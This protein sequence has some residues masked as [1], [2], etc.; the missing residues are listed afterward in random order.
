MAW[1]FILFHA[2]KWWFIHRETLTILCSIWLLV[3]AASESRRITI[4]RSAFPSKPRCLLSSGEEFS[5][6]MKSRNFVGASHSER[7]GSFSRFGPLEASSKASTAGYSPSR[8]SFEHVIRGTKK[9]RM[10]YEI[11]Q[12]NGASFQQS[13]QHPAR[14]KPGQEL[15]TN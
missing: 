11:Q 5:K 7:H 12:V 8:D 14:T 2:A 9:V 10:R 13:R 6:T 3:V 1:K 15:T 4:T